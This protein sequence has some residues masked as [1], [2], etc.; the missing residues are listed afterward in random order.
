MRITKLRIKNLFGI[1]EYAGNGKNVELAGN[2]GTG[3]SSVIDAIRFALTNKSNRDYIIRNGESEGEILVETDTGL[4]IH[5]KKRTEKADYRM[6]KSPN[7]PDIKESVLR[8]IFTELQLNPVEFITMSNEEQ[9]RIILDMIDF[10]WD[11]NW[12]KEQ[13]GE[14]VPEVNYEQNILAVLHDIQAEEG[15]YFKNRRA[16]N[17]EAR[18]K[19]AFIEEIG[20]SLPPNYSPENWKNNNLGELYRKI[21][22]IRHNNEQIETAKRLIASR[23]NKVRGFDAELQI[24]VNAIDKETSAERTSLEKYIIALENKIKEAQTR[25]SWL[26][27]KK[28][29]RIEL[30][31]A[32]Y[33]ANVAKLDGEIEQ[34]KPIADKKVEDFQWLQNE[35]EQIEEMKAHLNEYDRM[36]SLQKDVEDLK[37]RSDD[38]TAKIEKARA[39]PG[40]ILEKANIP[41]EGLSIKDGIPLINDLPLS[42]LSDGEKLALCVRVAV[43]KQEN[44]N[45][46]LI[47]GAERLSSVNREKLYEELKKKGVQFISTRTDDSNELQVTE[48]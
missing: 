44:L 35:A 15:Y 3:K 28:L 21:E 48:I 27:E 47:D 4:S 45:I 37:V 25:M 24:A 14:I 32:K 13:F 31:K 16:A 18:N 33:K 22:T 8:E 19:V 42:N 26:E 46:L 36:V 6:V 7:N 38:F 20:K 11:L 43:H 41:L 5:R 9:N 39:L 17:T 40:E 2:N 1:R 12:I 23:D 10:K 29:S 34:Y 30:E